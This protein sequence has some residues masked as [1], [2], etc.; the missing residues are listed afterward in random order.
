[1]GT[2]SF[3]AFNYFLLGY[4]YQEQ[5]N[6]TPNKFFHSSTMLHS[7]LTLVP[8]KLFLIS[9]SLFD[10]WKSNSFH[11]KWVN[12]NLKCQRPFLSLISFS[13]IDWFLFSVLW[14]LNLNFLYA[15]SFTDLEQYKKLNF[16]NLRGPYF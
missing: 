13:L 14:I 16:H 4:L 2:Y 10:F 15:I 3:L 12:F 1:M 5:E 7:I 6:R 8:E 11:L 9:I